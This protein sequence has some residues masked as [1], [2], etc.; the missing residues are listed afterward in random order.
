MF[1]FFPCLAPFGRSFG[2]VVGVPGDVENQAKTLEGL[3]KS[4]FGFLFVQVGFLGLNSRLT[5]SRFRFVAYCGFHLW[6]FGSILVCKWSSEKGLKKESKRDF[7][8][9]RGK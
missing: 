6:R 4:H 5:F 9:T 1:Y 3:S 2:I 7:K 8:A